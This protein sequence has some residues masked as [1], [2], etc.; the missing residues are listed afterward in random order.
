MRE[1]A[2]QN[3]SN[4]NSKNRGRTKVIEYDGVRFNGTWE[5][6]FYKWAKKNN[7]TI[8]R[9]ETGFPYEYDGIRTYYPDFFLEC[10][11]IYVEIK[12]YETD[13]DLAKWRCFP[14][15]L[16]VLKRKEISDIMRNSFTLDDLSCSSASE[17]FQTKL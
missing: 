9:V 13:K 15:K 7:I 11:D 17:P 4:Y 8:S 2:K 3:P 10:L 16:K 1:V 6:E 5:V 14:H 12:G